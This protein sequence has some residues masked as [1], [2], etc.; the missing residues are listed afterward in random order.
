[1]Y[2]S[3]SA[4]I[5]SITIMSIGIIDS[6]EKM[7]KEDEDED[8]NVDDDNNNDIGD[9]NIFVVAPP[10]APLVVVAGTKLIALFFSN[11][12]IF[13]FIIFILKCIV[14]LFFLE[15]ISTCTCSASDD[16]VVFFDDNTFTCGVGCRSKIYS[17]HKKTLQ[18]SPPI[19]I[20]ICLII[21]IIL[22]R[23]KCFDLRM[24]YKGACCCICSCTTNW[25]CWFSST[26]SLSAFGII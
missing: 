20:G 18:N 22:I 21:I 26:S 5:A 2:K 25:R 7:E 15:F 12:I 24:A 16:F 1:M 14:F 4:S 19:S 3:R 8:Q 13:N 17:M 9:V 23:L 10:V 11:V 6:I